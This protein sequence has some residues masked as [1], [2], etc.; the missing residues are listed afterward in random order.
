MARGTFYLYFPD[1]LA[2]FDQL[3]QC[4]FVGLRQVLDS[5]RGQLEQATDRGEVL[6]IYEGVG[7]G[8]ATVG[9]THQQEILVAF[10]SPAS[11]ARRACV[12]ATWNYSS[13][14]PWSI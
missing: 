7:L 8:L 9:L 6:D 2:L 5:V 13:S 3:M 1:K 4:W 11:P 14:T 10:R 12:C